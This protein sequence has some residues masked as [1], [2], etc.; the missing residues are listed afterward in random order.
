MNPYTFDKK[1]ILLEYPLGRH[2]LLHQ[3]ILMS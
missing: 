1:I 2:V 3:E